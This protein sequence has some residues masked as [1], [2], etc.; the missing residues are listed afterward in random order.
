MRKTIC[1]VCGKE[2]TDI[3]ESWN[4]SI[5]SNVSTRLLKYDQTDY[6]LCFT[7]VCNDCANSI[8]HCIKNLQEDSIYH[9]STGLQKEE[10]K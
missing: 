6:S 9:Y 4:V 1:D 7:D 2:I 3:R 10:N 8:Y 5:S